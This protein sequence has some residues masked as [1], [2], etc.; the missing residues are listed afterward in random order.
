M[1]TMTDDLIDIVVPVW[2]RPVETGACLVAVIEQTPNAR[3]VIVDNSSDRE[4]ERMLEEI[5]EALDE[6]IL[7][8]RN[9][10][11]EG[12]VR[13]VNRGLERAESRYTALVRYNSVV[14]A[15]WLEPLLAFANEN[16]DA[17]IIVPSFS[18]PT[19]SR[20]RLSTGMEVRFGDFAAMLLNRRLV[21][22]AGGFKEDSDGALWC[23]KEYSRRA[24]RA[25]FRT[26]VVPEAVVAKSEDA[27]L[28]SPVRRA[29]LEKRIKAEYRDAW[30][31]ENSYCLHIPKGADLS[32]FRSMLPVMLACVR[33]GNRLSVLV[34]PR[35][36]RDLRTAGVAQLH[37]DLRIGFLP[38]LMP[39]KTVKKELARLS[40]AGSPVQLVGWPGDDL[41]PGWGETIP[42]S[43]L[44]SSV[45]AVEQDIYGRD[46]G[47]DR[48]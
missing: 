23:L 42:F 16:N 4:T 32:S 14:T 25:G 8:F 20:E 28:G 12:F 1:P 7:L 3:L 6:R 39:G 9:S 19:A 35:H 48:F 46:L 40:A 31:T 47:A 22:T 38:R 44:E 41:L 13:A 18:G 15:G 36:S 24:M 27:T 26:C 5:A 30:G 45:R 2:N 43:V 10:A 33:Q 34:H 17:G 21:E 11:N 37:S 29:E